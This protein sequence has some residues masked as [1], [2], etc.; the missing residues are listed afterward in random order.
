MSHS[1]WDTRAIN[2]TLSAHTAGRSPAQIHAQL[3]VNGYHLLR[4][5]TVEQCLRLHGR[6]IP[7]A[8]PTYPPE[9]YQGI[10]WNGLADNFALSAF[11]AGFS[12]NQI[13]QQLL[14]KGY[15]VSL[16]QVVCSLQAQGIQEI[17][18]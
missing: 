9:N 1:D 14:E 10:D 18:F 5:I 12:A 7:L 16:A 2:F 11:C 8:L 13:W 6:D 15:V 3:V 4:L 17:V